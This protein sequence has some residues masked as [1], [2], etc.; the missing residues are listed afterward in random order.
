LSLRK[1]Q[2]VRAWVDDVCSS[3]SFRQI[4]PCH[5]AAPV[6]AGPAEFKRAFAFAYEEQDE[7]L[8]MG[9]SPPLAAVPAI[10]GFG[11]LA[12][13]LRGARGVGLGQAQKLSRP[14]VFPEADMR[15]LNTLN[16]SLLRLGVVKANAD[17]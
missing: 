11:W 8:E 3:W 10:P 4:I 9:A 7:E 13:L 17:N 6:K 12:G 2:Q 14:V 5:F 15:T 1:L 16:N